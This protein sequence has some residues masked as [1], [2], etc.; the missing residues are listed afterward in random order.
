MISYCEV[1]DTLSS[2]SEYLNGVAS[3]LLCVCVC[4]AASVLIHDGARCCVTVLVICQHKVSTNCN[5]NFY[6]HCTLQ[7]MKLK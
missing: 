4:L 2:E 3:L 7:R 6:L 5:N 1:I